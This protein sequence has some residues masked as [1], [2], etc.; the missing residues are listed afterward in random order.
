MVVSG[1]RQLAEAQAFLDTAVSAPPTGG[2]HAPSWLQVGNAISGRT[3][4]AAGRKVKRDGREGGRCLPCTPKCKASAH[5]AS[6]RE[7]AAAVM[8]GSV[9][10][11]LEML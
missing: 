4:S 8:K 11:H 5:A 1:E 3:D 10:S 6:T 7:T 9:S 2:V